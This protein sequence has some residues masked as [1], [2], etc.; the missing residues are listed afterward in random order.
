MLDLTDLRKDPV[1]FKK[2]ILKKEPSFDV[3]S[4]LLLD[5]QF[6]SM[7]LLIE[8]LRKEKNDLASKAK[9]GITEE[10][11]AQSIQVGKNLKEKEEQLSSVENQFKT[12]LLSCPNILSKDVPA[13]NKENNKEVKI[14][15][16]K[17]SFD[18]TP[19]DHV[20]LGNAL[21]WFDFLGAAKMT[22]SNFALYKGDGV[23]LMYALTSLMIK[24]NM[25]H[26]FDPILPPYLVNTKS[27]TTSG[28]LPKFAD[29]AYKIQDEDL[30]LTPTSEVNLLNYYRDTIFKTEEL[31]KRLTAWTSCFRRE[32]G[33]YGHA[34]RGLIR[35]HQFEKVE[36]VAVTKPED[37][38]QELDRMMACAE[39]ILQ[40]LG[41]HYRVML[42]AAQ[43]TS[44]QSH[45]TYDI[46][47][48]MPGQSSYY[49]VSSA[50]N[51]T[52]FQARRAKMRYRE[53]EGAKTSYVHTLNASSLA[54]PRLMVALLET[55][56]QKDGSV[57]LPDCLKEQG[58]L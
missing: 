56:Q 26:G 36:L 47:V 51:C 33:N 58:W 19:K 10:I 25:K 34:E 52:D 14:V 9:N 30:Y 39:D 3:D 53:H 50:S 31:P 5:E 24:N 23:K 18:F 48:W 1:Q 13:G 35:I 38:E 16:N 41:L 44:F 8:S 55:Y 29:G 7:T 45:K 4:L 6:R 37:S 57:V 27:M 15:G 32:A 20:T 12:L 11:R 43:D 28:Q 49:E 2:E 54:L 21:G 42:L 17:Q 46:E 22:G 40:Q